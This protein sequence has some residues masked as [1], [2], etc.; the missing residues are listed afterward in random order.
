M[1]RKNYFY[2]LFAKKNIT[3]EEMA[4][5]MGIKKDSL[6]RKLIGKYGFNEKDI[7]IILDT[8]DMDFKEVFI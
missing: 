2:D 7:K 6:Y 3:I 5:K 4:Q 8:L 1:N